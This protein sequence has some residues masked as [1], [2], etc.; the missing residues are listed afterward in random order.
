MTPQRSGARLT[1]FLGALAAAALFR[2]VHRPVHAQDAAVMVLVWQFGSVALF[3]TTIG[4]FG[5]R[6]L[7]WRLEPAG[8]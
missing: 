3:A 8:R 4:A 5:G 2:V 6:P 7:S 1:I